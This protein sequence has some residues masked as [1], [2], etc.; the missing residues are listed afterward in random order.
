MLKMENLNAQLT[1]GKKWVGIRE[2][3]KFEEDNQ[4]LD[5]ILTQKSIVEDIKAFEDSKEIKSKG[6]K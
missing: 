4:T 5:W 2:K 6:K 1:R 3:A